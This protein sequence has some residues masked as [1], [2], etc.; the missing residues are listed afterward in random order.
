MRVVFHCLRG[1]LTLGGPTPRLFLGKGDACGTADKSTCSVD[2]KT[3]INPTSIGRSFP[4]E[5]E[6]GWVPPAPYPIVRLWYGRRGGSTLDP[7]AG[8]WK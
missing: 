3:F 2:V 1:G 7:E 4:R 5:Y 8:G 6:S